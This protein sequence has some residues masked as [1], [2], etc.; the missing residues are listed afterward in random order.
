[1]RIRWLAL[2]ALGISLIAGAAQADDWPQWRGSKRDGISQEKNL[3]KLWPKDGPK[4]LWQVK[5][6]GFGYGSVAVAGGRL[7]LIGNKGL[8]NEFVMALDARTGDILWTTR[9]GNVGKP[10][11]VPNYAAARSTPTVDGAL[12]YALGSDG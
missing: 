12:L 5:D 4:L 7:Y 3:L 6:L 1:M 10:K 9:I 8:D 2:A 11:Q